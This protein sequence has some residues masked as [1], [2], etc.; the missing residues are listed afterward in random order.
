MKLFNIRGRLIGKNVSKYQIDWDAPSPSKLQFSVKQFLKTYWSNHY[1]YE[2]FPVYGSRMRVDILNATRKIAV[3]VHGQQHDAFNKFFHN[4]SRN[5]YRA[6]IER[7]VDKYNWLTKNNFKIIE[8]YHHEVK[9]LTSQFI[10]EKY[11]IT[12]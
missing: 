5:N 2:E 11:G 1:V 9:G 10:L 7:D 8:I 12:L 6:S 4:N 3:E